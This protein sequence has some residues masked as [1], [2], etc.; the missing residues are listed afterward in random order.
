MNNPYLALKG[1]VFHK[2]TMTFDTETGEEI[3]DTSNDELWPHAEFETW[4]VSRIAA[5]SVVGV[6][7]IAIAFTAVQK[8]CIKCWKGKSCGNCCDDCLGPFC[9]PFWIGCLGGIWLHF[10]PCIW[11]TCDWGL[12]DG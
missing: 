4:P 2:D 3:R 11:W 6:L 9:G 7:A 10:I 1:P 8:Y 5:L 12:H